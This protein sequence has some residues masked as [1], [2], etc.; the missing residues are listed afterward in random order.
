MYVVPGSP[1]EAAG[2]REGDTVLAFD[3]DSSDRA[4]MTH[5]KPEG[6]T[7]VFTIQRAGEPGPRDVAITIGHF[8]LLQLESRV[9]DGTVG[10]LR[11]FSWEQ[12]TGQAQAIRDAIAGFEQQGVRSWIVDVRANG[13]GVMTTITNLFMSSGV[14]YRL[15][16][17]SGAGPTVFADGNAIQPQRPLVF[18]VGPGSGSASEIAPEALREAGDAILVGDHTAGCMATTSETRLSDGSSLWVTS[19]HVLIGDSGTELE[20]IGVTPDIMAPRT[21]DDIVAGRDPGLD[22]AVNYLESVTA[23][24]APQPV[25]GGQ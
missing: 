5:A 10:Y 15:A 13:G 24:S 4:P 22:A 18:L 14:I 20:G 11:F 25:A 7:T 2:L 17:R 8:H 21:P 16:Q 23:G 9:I 1:A 6:Q 12:G 3:G 19:Q